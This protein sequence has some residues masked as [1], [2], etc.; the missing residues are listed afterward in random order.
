MVK[1]PKICKLEKYGSEGGLIN[2]HALLLF[3]HSSLCRTRERDCPNITKFNSHFGLWILL[4]MICMK[5]PNFKVADCH[6]QSASQ[7]PRV[8]KEDH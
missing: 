2:S 7:S 6:W 8:D 3:W 5:G 1:Y 4:H